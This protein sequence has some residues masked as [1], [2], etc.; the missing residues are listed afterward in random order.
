MVRCSLR[1]QLGS[2]LGRQPGPLDYN[3]APRVTYSR[4]QVASV[5]M[6]E[7]QAKASGRKARSQRFSFRYNAM[8]L[9][10]D[11]PEGF[12][13]VVYDTDTGDL[14]G[15]HIIGHHASELI[16]EASLARFVEASAWE[17]G[18]NIHPHPTLSETLGEAA[19]LS[20]GISIY[21]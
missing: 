11:E 15:A 13:K 7:E 1:T 9:I 19:Q 17:M 18:T 20:A 2:G 12:A 21:R 8:A 14:L 3:R 16:S 4:P 10:Q 6:T 5:G